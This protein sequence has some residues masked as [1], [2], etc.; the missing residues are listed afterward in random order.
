MPALIE[1]E[2]PLLVLFKQHKIEA[3]AVVWNDLTVNWKVYDMLVLRSIWDYH[4][5]YRKFSNWLT[6]IEKEH[7]PTLNST[8]IVRKNQNKFYLKELKA[9]GVNIVPTHFINGT[10]RLDLSMVRNS[11][12]QKAV[13][14]PAISASAYMTEVFSKDEISTIEEKYQYLAAGRD[15]LIQPFMEEIISSGE[16]S[17]IFFN[18]R[19]S[20]SVL[21]TTKGTDFRVQAEY[22]GK[23]ST[24]TPEEHI[25]L[26]ASSI[27]SHF[28]GDL[29]YARIDG[30][31]SDRHF[32][33]MEIELIE[34]DLFFDYASSSHQRFVE[35]TLE[36]I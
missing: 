11:N 13:I 35:A 10:D 36:L 14:K 5:H 6:L 4:H 16:I 21:K 22:G 33:L 1:S 8:S 31:I 7:I 3:E 12:W 9:R 24:C 34:P 23:V 17:L 19:Y 27:L 29:L 18:R 25:I 32:M 30:I 15:L 26:E 28:S 2:R 20:H